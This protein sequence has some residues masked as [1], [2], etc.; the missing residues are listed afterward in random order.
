[1]RRR[2]TSLGLLAFLGLGTVAFA[3]VTGTVNDA[4]NLP[5]ADIEIRVKGTDKVAYTDENGNFNIDAKVGDTLVINGKEFKVTSNKLGA[6]K[7]SDETKELGEVVVT[8]YTTL[9]KEKVA[10]AVSIVDGKDLEGIPLTSFTQMLAGKAPGVDLNIGSGQPGSNATSVV[11]RGQGSING[12]STPLYVV[13]GVQVN[14]D[15]FGNLNPN[16]FES[17]S[18]L[19]D[20][21]AKAQYGSQAGNGVIIVTTKRGKGVD[22]MTINLN[23]SIGV[24]LLPE[25]KFEM[26][27]TQE[28]LETQLKLGGYYSGVNDPLYVANSKINTDWQKE[29]MRTGITSQHDLS[30][31][32]AS[33]NSNYY[34]GLGRLDQEGIVKNTDFQ[35]TTATINL[36][37]GNGSNFR[38]GLNSNFGF[39]KRNN[40]S[41]EAS[42]NLNNPMATAYLGLPYESLY[43]ADGKTLNVGS[44]RTAQ[45]AYERLMKAEY[46]TQQIKAV[47]GLFAEYDFNPIFTFR[48][49]GGL[50][51]TGEFYKS[52]TDPNTY[53][54]STTT[55]GNAGN[56]GRSYYQYDGVNTN[57]MLKFNKA[58][59]LHKVDGYVATEYV[60]KF[61]DG[62]G[63]TAYGLNTEL[64]NVVSATQ[65]TAKILPAISGTEKSLHIISYFANVNYSFDDRFILSGNVRRDGASFFAPGYEWGT[66]GGAAAAWNMTREEF[67]KNSNIISDLKVRASWGTLGNAGDL[68]AISAYNNAKMLSQ[69]QYDGNPTYGASGPL[70]AEYR[71]EKEEQWNV[72]VDFGLFNNRVT[73]SFDYYNRLT[74][75]LYVN[76]TLSLTSGF[77]SMS[78]FNGGKMRNRGIEAQINVDIIRNSNTRLTFDANYAYNKNEIIDLGEVSQY[79]SGTSIIK[80]GLPYG[81]HYAVKWGGVDPQTGKPWYYD[82][83]GNRM[84]VF[85]GSQAVAE[86]GSYRPVHMGGFGL[87]FQHKGFFIDA[88]F[89]FKA[90]Y[91]RYNNQRFFNENAAN[92]GA[93]NQYKVVST[94]WTKPGDVTD[95]QSDNYGLQFSSKFIEDASF[96]RLRNLRVGYTID[97]K[98][99]NQIGIQG[100][101]IYATGTNLLTWTKW[102]G[103]DPDDANNIAQYEYPSPRIV[104]LGVNLTF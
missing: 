96:L 2:L 55:P 79:E 94:V 63:F 27:S 83:E 14:A 26:M 3:Q 62:F 12:G 89:Q 53:F 75:D 34:I 47:A 58:W 25:A 5:E 102:T 44:G 29:F 54:G 95:I 49:Y 72:G 45:N 77:E 68:F 82:K 88:D 16:S 76:Q 40:M 100:A 78:N 66:F 59:G 48:L 4:S 21:A 74:K 39:S 103:L 38:V 87:E 50:D 84:D 22:K 42:V 98:L 61:V 85:D 11:I 101:T 19:K 57:A 86:F 67:I 1:M 24:T 80:E 71:W 35:R 6:V 99:M 70:N 32:G 13:D 65:V 81:T 36:G 73:G 30:V 17:V 37:S 43:K 9:K 91:K 60:G 51:H 7:F 104:T 33:K 23:S 10:T 97:P 28:I 92:I 31:S 90:G 56:L 69:G 18:I 93:Y 52:Y 8:G 15:V 46:N 41:S 20:A 64:G